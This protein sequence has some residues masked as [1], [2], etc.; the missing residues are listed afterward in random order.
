[1]RLAEKQEEEEQVEKTTAKCFAFHANAI[2]GMHQTLCAV[3]DT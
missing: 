3:I 1:M 2:R